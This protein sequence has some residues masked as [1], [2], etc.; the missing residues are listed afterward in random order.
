MREVG[1][2][3]VLVDERRRAL[4]VGVLGAER[5][6]VGVRRDAVAEHVPVAGGRENAVQLDARQHEQP[7]G[8]RRLGP[9]PVVGDREDVVAG[10]LVVRRERLGLELAVGAGR[11]RV[12]RAAQPLAF[13][14]EGI[15][16][17][18]CHTR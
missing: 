14:R 6:E 7:V 17:I 3:A 5:G 13:G 9:L 18:R 15:G 10:A 1:D 4:E 11:V 8:R 16:A 2:A 12:E